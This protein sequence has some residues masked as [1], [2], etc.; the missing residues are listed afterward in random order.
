MNK[1]T[2]ITAIGMVGIVGGTVALVLLG[3]E[4][5]QITAIVEGVAVVVA[6]IAAIFGAT[7]MAKNKK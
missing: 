3:K 2:V 1:N 4:T 6:L 7:K 5:S